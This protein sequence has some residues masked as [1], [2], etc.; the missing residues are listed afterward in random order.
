M[1]IEEY[2]RRAANCHAKKYSLEILDDDTAPRAHH[3]D[4]VTHWKN[5]RPRHYDRAVNGLRVGHAWLIARLPATWAAHRLS[6]GRRLIGGVR[7]SEGDLQAERN[8]IDAAIRAEK[9]AAE[10]VRT[11]RRWAAIEDRRANDRDF[12]SEEARLFA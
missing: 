12:C 1:N 4:G 10:A 9:A 11:A 3:K 5:G 7:V 6:G 8:A 2:C